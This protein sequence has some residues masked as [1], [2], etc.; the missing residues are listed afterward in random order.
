MVLPC[1]FRYFSQIGDRY[2]HSFFSYYPELRHPFDISR[3][4]FSL[5]VHDKESEDEEFIRLLP[6]IKREATDERNFVKKAVNWA[7]RN[8]GKRN[9]NLNRIAIK[10]AREIQLIDFKA[11]RWVASGAIRELESEAVQRRLKK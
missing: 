11:A 10:T 3:F 6:V 1:F 5:A 7:L 8:I 2:S 9:I 4:G